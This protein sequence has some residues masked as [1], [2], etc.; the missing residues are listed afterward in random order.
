MARIGSTS[1]TTSTTLAV[2]WVR[3]AESAHSKSSRVRTV[4]WPSAATAAALIASMAAARQSSS[5]AGTLPCGLCPRASFWWFVR[6]D[7]ICFHGGVMPSRSSRRT[8]SRCS[9]SASCRVGSTR[10]STAVPVSTR[11]GKPCTPDV[12]LEGLGHELEAEAREAVPLDPGARSA[13]PPAQLRVGD[14][15][16]GLEVLAR[17]D[18]RAVGA[19]DAEG[20]PQVARA[21]GPSRSPRC[22]SAHRR[23]AGATAASAGPSAPA[24]GSS[25]GRTALAWSGAGTMS[26]RT[27]LGSDRM[28]AVTSSS[29]K[30][31]TCHS[32][33]SAVTWLSRSTGTCTVTPSAA[34]PG[35]NW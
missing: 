35:S 4:R 20:D 17:G 14:V 23:G 31:G 16:D 25:S 7:R 29:R 8:P 26:R 6:R 28:R 18:R 15:A 19:V 13:D 21:R 30:P 34:D 1:P 27:P 3:T 33:P 24:V 5:R 10:R 32:K 22:G 9:A 11:A 2:V 12:A